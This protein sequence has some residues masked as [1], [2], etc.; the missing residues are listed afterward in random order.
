[1]SFDRE[2]KKLCDGCFKFFEKEELVS[3]RSVRLC[4]VCYNMIWFDKS[5]KE[6]QER[7]KLNE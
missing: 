1:M 2:G 6:F 3:V 7:L 4:P 5:K